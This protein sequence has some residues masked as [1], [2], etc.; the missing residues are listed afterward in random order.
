M[1]KI[2]VDTID[3][4]SGTFTLTLGSS[5]AGTIALGSGDV[6][7]NFNYPAFIATNNTST[8][9]SGDTWTVYTFDAE[10]VDTDS[11]FNTSTY[12]FTVPSGKA[13]TYLFT[14]DVSW[15]TA[16]DGTLMS[17]AIAKNGSRFVTQQEDLGSTQSLN[18]SVTGII[19]CSAG[20]EIQAYLRHAHSGNTEN[21]G[22]GQRFSG[23]RIGT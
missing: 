5:N 18:M 11:A 15:S 3:T 23:F 8:S 9:M 20:D 17:V 2:L 12:K 22:T 1:S 16:P 10:V 21:T 6:Q 13:G 14:V 7:S 19:N 4:R